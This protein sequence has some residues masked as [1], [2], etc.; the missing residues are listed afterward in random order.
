MATPATAPANFS[1]SWTMMRTAVLK[2][3]S[4]VRGERPGARDPL[5][6]AAAVASL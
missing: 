2:S 6:A 5:V 4:V 3:M 1:F